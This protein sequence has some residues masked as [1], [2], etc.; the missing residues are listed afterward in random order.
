MR[1][2]S[3][4]LCQQAKATCPNTHEAD[5][6]RVTA[7]AEEDADDGCTTVEGE[8][9]ASGAPGP[10]IDLVV[11]EGA[12]ELFPVPPEPTS[13]LELVALV[14]PD[15]RAQEMPPITCPR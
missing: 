4:F 9:D 5:D 6:D 3:T 10:D 11:D 7:G 2:P 15:C 1:R 8:E 14:V 12:V 13:A